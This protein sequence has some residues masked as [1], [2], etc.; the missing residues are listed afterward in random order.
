MA[1]ARK[2][3]SSMTSAN[4]RI[5]GHT[6]VRCKKP[7]GENDGGFG[8]GAGGGDSGAFDAGDS[9]ANPGAG[10]E[11]NWGAASGANPGDDG[12]GTAPAAEAS[13]APAW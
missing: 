6:I 2:F 4:H 8:S 12:W 1:Q 9:M 11:E 5:V 7:V 10:D 13:T 3:V